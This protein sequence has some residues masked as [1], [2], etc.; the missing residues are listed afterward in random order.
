MMNKIRFHWFAAAIVILCVIIITW[1]TVQYIQDV[2][3]VRKDKAVVWNEVSFPQGNVGTVVPDKVAPG[4]TLVVT[5]KEYCNNGVDVTIERWVDFYSETQ[6]DIIVASY[7]LVP[8][9]FFGSKVPGGCFAP[10]VQNVT[11]PIDLEGR[12]AGEQVVRLRNITTYEKP[13]QVIRVPSYTEKFILL[14]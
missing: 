6:P 2:Q 11:I 8:V 14:P 3:Q 13:E 4:E 9:Q 1:F 5:Q 12:P 10:L 7:G